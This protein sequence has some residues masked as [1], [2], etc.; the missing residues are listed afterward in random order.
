MVDIEALV[1]NPKNPNNHGEKQITMLAKILKFQGWRLPVIVSKRSGYVVA[2]HGRIAAAK[3]NGW[4]QIPVDD[5]DFESEAQEY[6]HLIADNKI[7]ELAEHDDA[8][9]IQ[10]L[11]DMNFDLDFDLLG[12]KDFSLISTDEFSD[13]QDT[14]MESDI[15]YRIEVKFPN[16]MEMNDIKDDLMSRGYMVKVL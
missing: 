13:L 11:K 3:L 1:L 14:S 7:A 6:A 5:Q 12:I 4:T 16:D 8:M 15:Q 2:G 10:D 9:M